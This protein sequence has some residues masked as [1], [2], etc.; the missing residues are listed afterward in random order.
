VEPIVRQVLDLNMRYYKALGLAT[1]E[2]AQGLASFWSR[3]VRRDMPAP[4]PFTPPRPAP[5]VA[6]EAAPPAILVL[7][8]AAGERAVGEFAVANQLTRPVSATFEV[9]AFRDPSGNDVRVAVEIEPAR[10]TLDPGQQAVVRITAAISKNLQ[11]SV[12][13]AGAV[14]VPG[15]ADRP[16][17]IIVR[18]AAVAAA[19]PAKP[20]RKRKAPARA[21]AQRR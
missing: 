1:L 16:I 14:S 5:A 4:S 8:A 10:L 12:P 7:E 13:Y 21:R 19:A 2:Y 3:N 17:P 18:R 9:S 20:R 6:R 15:L 11:A